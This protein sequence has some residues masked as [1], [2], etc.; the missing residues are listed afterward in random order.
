[1][2]RKKLLFPVPTLG[3]G[4]LLGPLNS[5]PAGHPTN[6]KNGGRKQATTNFDVS[7]KTGEQVDKLLVRKRRSYEFK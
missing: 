6:S 3:R 2:E 5:D 7:G 1:M 4:W